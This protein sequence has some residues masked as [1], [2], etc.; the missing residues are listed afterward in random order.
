MNVEEK[1]I[2]EEKE[3]S[4]PML[5]KSL[6]V[7]TSPAQVISTQAEK[8]Y[9]SR[10]HGRYRFARRV[11]I[12]D[13]ALLGVIVGLI[14][15]TTGKF[16][17]PPKTPEIISLEMTV[18]PTVPHAGDHVELAFEYQNESR[19]R[20]EDVSI[21]LRLS[22]GFLMDE[23]ETTTFVIGTLDPGA[24]GAVELSGTLIAE[25]HTP[26]DIVAIVSIRGEQASV[27]SFSIPVGDSA[28]AVELTVPEEIVAGDDTS[29]AFAYR[30]RGNSSIADVVVV[31]LLPEG[32][33]IVAGDP[34]LTEGTWRIL[35][36]TPGTS[37]ERILDVRFPEGDMNV[38][39]RIAF[40]ALDELIPQ[41]EIVRD[42]R[43]VAPIV[44]PHVP[45]ELK[46]S[47]VARYYTAEGEQI[48]RGPFPPVAGD[49]T[50][51][52]I[53][54][55]AETATGTARDVVVTGRLPAE[56]S[57]TGVQSV[58]AKGA[59]TIVYDPRSRTVRWEIPTLSGEP[60]GAGF[61]V[62]VVPTE[63]QMGSSISV[64]ENI[65]I[66]GAG[67]NGEEITSIAD[68]VRL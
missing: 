47:A 25:P 9:Q 24:R 7:F 44:R 57:W 43:V 14:V 11:F 48:G 30:N 21:A 59:E 31:P 42:V 61:A 32:A 53:F 60:A 64:F 56:V 49:T 63:K 16:L 17:A 34:P 35:G 2:I 29:L 26:S 52:W 1:V 39:F 41:G 55:N 67:E 18:N 27:R 13:L 19:E 20:Q 38:G 51:V 5:K 65:T 40:R 66:R 6:S 68:D 62:D 8:H 45:V 33:E 28:L 37:G 54:V 15:F 22:R 46:V 23:S 12:F 58:A 50:R 36:I 3:K 10:Y 4:P